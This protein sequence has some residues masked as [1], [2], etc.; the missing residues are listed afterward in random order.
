MGRQKS[1]DERKG[2]RN[3]KG[4]Y[5]VYSKSGDYSFE[6]ISDPFAVLDVPDSWIED[7]EREDRLLKKRDSLLIKEKK[8][9]KA[10]EKGS[11][12]LGVSSTIQG[13]CKVDEISDLELFASDSGEAPKKKDVGYEVI[14][15]L[16]CGF[17]KHN[18]PDDETPIQVRNEKG[19]SYVCRDCSNEVPKEM[20]MKKLETSAEALSIK[21]VKGKSMLA[22]GYVPKKYAKLE[23]KLKFLE[24]YLE[25]LRL[26]GSGAKEVASGL[27]FCPHYLFAAPTALRRYE[28]AKDRYTCLYSGGLWLGGLTSVG[29]VIPAA[30]V[31]ALVGNFGAIGAIIGTQMVSAGYE[32]LR[33]KTLDTRE[34]DG[35]YDSLRDFIFNEGHDVARKQ[36]T[37]KF[38]YG[39]VVALEG[40]NAVQS[41]KIQMDERAKAHRVRP[42]FKETEISE[43]NF[44]MNIGLAQT[45]KSK[46]GSSSSGG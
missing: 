26:V 22:L 4:H 6:S 39:I 31:A 18:V 29:F 17:G 45:L 35:A 7:C 44:L 33:P 24:P 5:L 8:T 20:F 40:E 34:I 38:P 1:S 27:A 42:K 10:R 3:K 14:D 9:R 37:E 28:N 32:F 43:G 30:A 25:P 41:L 15:D 11:S 21:G 46:Y 16:V 23:E 12:G 13:S 19:K 36:H 2:K